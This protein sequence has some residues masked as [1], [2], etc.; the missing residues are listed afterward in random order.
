MQINI[1]V[2]MTLLDSSLF[3]KDISFSLSD[4]HC[5]KKILEPKKS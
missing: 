2:K 1:K 3:Q 4:L 5:Q